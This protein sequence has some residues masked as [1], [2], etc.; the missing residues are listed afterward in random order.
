M[1]LFSRYNRI[2]L[3]GTV[4][5]FLMAS[6]AYYFLLRHVLINEVDK[7]LTI[8]KEEIN[9]YVARFH[10]FPEITGTEEQPIH[11]H[12]VTAA[13][14]R[15]PEVKR[16]ITDDQDPPFREIS[17]YQQVNGQ[18]YEVVVSKSL[19]QTNNI[20]QSVIL[21]TLLTILLI[22]TA[23]VLINRLILR[24]LWQPFYYTLDKVKAFQL[25]RKEQLTFPVSDIEE[26]ILLN[27]TLHSTIQKAERDYLLLKEFT[28]N[29]SHE[30]QTPL[31]I[32][33]SKMDVLI[34]DEQLTEPQSHV[35]QG[36]YEAIQKLSHL[37]KSLLLLARIENQQFAAVAPVHLSERI[38]D[39]T[40]QFKELWEAKSLTVSIELLPVT[41]SMNEELAEIL[42]NNL[43]GNATRYTPPQGQILISLTPEQLTISNTGATA[44]LPADTLFTRFY[45]EVSSR[46]GNGLGLSIIQQICDISG[47]T[48]QYHYVNQLHQF[49]VFFKKE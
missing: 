3:A 33:R 14:N 34:Q 2:N 46:E 1:K 25:G 31:A 28:E 7:D 24:K 10:K 20:I 4:I 22:L 39:K 21:I 26:F 19:E 12:P 23:S 17:F 29:A 6:L 32:I 42:L 44:A 49:R 38:T 40:T 11:Y 8:E 36:V 16:Y 48:V 5:I 13:T 15:T 35:L 27:H 37:N 45:K 43:L 47:Y 30:M 41:L 18:L 9:T